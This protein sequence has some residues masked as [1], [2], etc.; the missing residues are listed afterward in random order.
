MDREE[1]HLVAYVEIASVECVLR[2]I[3]EEYKD[4]LRDVHISY[5]SIGV[6]R[7]GFVTRRGR[8]DINLCA[9]LPPRVSLGRFLRK[10]QSALEFGA[11]SRGQWPPWAVRRF[12]LYDVL[13]HELGH[14]Q[15]VNPKSKNM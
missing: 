3:P 2:R 5:N 15:L 9:M 13:L 1:Q 7:L 10:S 11:P 14:L 8:R 4:R 12:M 6:R